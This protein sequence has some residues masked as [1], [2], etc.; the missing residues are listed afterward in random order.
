MALLMGYDVGSSSVKATL[1]EADTGRVLGA[2]TSP[3]RE[4]EMI[5]KKPGWAEQHPDTWWEHVQRATQQIRDKVAF[6]PGDVK[7]IGISYQ[8]HGLVIVDK[9]KQVLR[10]SIIWCDSRAVP[11]GRQAAKDLGAKKCLKRLLNLPGNFTASKLK[12]VKDNE[13]KIFSKIDRMMLPGDFIAMKMTDEIRTTPSGL[14]EGI[15]WDFEKDK[16]A[17]FVL[18]NYGI[19]TDLVAE[20]VPHRLDRP[21]YLG[22]L[23]E[24]GFFDHAHAQQDL[25]EFIHP[26]DQFGE[27]AAAGVHRFEHLQRG[28]DA[29]T[30]V[31]VIEEYGM[32]R[33]LAAQVRA[34][35]QHF[36]EHVLVSDPGPKESDPRPAQGDLQA[37][38]AHGRGHDRQGG[39]P[40][41]LLHV[42][43]LDEKGVV[44][45]ENGPFLVD[46][47]RPV[48]VAVVGDA[49]HGLD[50]AD[51]RGQSLRVERAAFPVDVPAVRGIVDH[52]DVVSQVPEDPGGHGRAGPV[53]AVKDYPL[54]AVHGVGHGPALEVLDIVVDQFGA[55]LG[56]G[57]VAGR[58]SGGRQDVLFEVGLPIVG[59]LHPG[60]GEYLDAVVGE[61]IVRRREDHSGR[62]AV[63]GREKGDRRGRDHPG[64]NRVAPGRAEAQDEGLFHPR[65]GFPGVPAYQDPERQAMRVEHPGQGAAQGL[66]GRYVERVVAGDRPYPVSSEE[67]FT[68]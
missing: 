30:G 24:R 29:V 62:E 61:R 64:R 34:P 45:V 16:L 4:L 46:P 48:G 27:R 23:I 57:P 35:S 15:M 11:I 40:P 38:V 19:P 54:A 42:H 10:P 51:L 63:F 1:M 68:H 21:G 56:S 31:Y 17:D 66:D 7:A 20:T 52:D 67:F 8:M 55:L 18:D 2:A 25:G 50:L 22:E 65:P 44:A 3:D 26:P 59:Y 49:H 47:D 53:G 39:E 5:A 43:G 37:E 41:G 14:S 36:L 33:A 58:L 9:K 12:W 28:Q 6:A 60:R 32:A 13:P